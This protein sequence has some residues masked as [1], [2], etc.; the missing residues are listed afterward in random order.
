[1]RIPFLPPPG[2]VSDDTT[3]SSE[4]RYADGSNV[5][6]WNG[7]P[8]TIGGWTTY[9]RTPLTGV[10]RSVLSWMDMTGL[11]NTVVFGT[12]SN[13]QVFSGGGL[14]DITPTGLAPGLVDSAGGSGY[15]ASTYSREGYGEPA[16]SG[17]YLR[18][19]SLANWGNNLVANPIGGGL[20]YWDGDTSNPATIVSTA[21]EQINSILVTP[22][23]QV[24]AFG[25]NE[26]VSSA[27]NTMCIRGSDLEDYT[28]WTTTAANNAFEHILEGSGRIVTARMFGSYV[29]VWTESSVYI[30][31]FIGDPGQTYRFDL[32]A[33]NCGLIGQNAVTVINQ[34]AYWIT[35]DGQ[36]YAW[37][38]GNPPAPIRCPIRSDFRDNLDP[39]QVSKIVCTGLG[40][41]NEVWWFY[42]DTRDGNENS[43]YLAYSITDGT[44]FRGQMARTAAVDS[45]AVPNPLM[46]TPGGVVYSHEF[47]ASA[48]GAPL[49]YFIET[50]DQYLNEAQEWIMLRGIWPDFEDQQGPVN[51]TVN[52]RPYPQSAA[53]TKGPYALSPGMQRRDFLA[54]GRVV[55][56]RFDGNSSPAYIRFGKPSFDVVGTGQQ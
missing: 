28:D 10:C 42:P 5:R 21:P 4:G 29:A 34:V 53:T 40:A 13:L 43:R 9:V 48:D 8:Q 50:A 11:R 39:S 6:F 22:E 1:M 55:S 26:E 19:W 12:H 44:W 3:F 18:T 38:I 33:T 31:Q 52:V 25:C 23:R 51:I 45:G 15:G 46:V 17:Y 30:G 56:V 49:A 32:V 35:P 47:G 54:S 16:T 14:Y 27:F 41:F 24:L 36:F 7:R 37:A 20:Y 2:I